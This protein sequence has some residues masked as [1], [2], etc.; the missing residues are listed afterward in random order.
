MTTATTRD[1][2]GIV[3]EDSAKWDPTERRA[4][5]LAHDLSHTSQ[6]G[7]RV[8]STAPFPAYFPQAS[9]QFPQ[10]SVQ[11]RLSVERV[12][13]CA[14]N[15][16]RRISIGFLDWGGQEFGVK[17]AEELGG[18]VLHLQVVRRITVVG[19]AVLEVGKSSLS[20][21]TR[22]CHCSILV[23]SSTSPAWSRCSLCV[24]RAV[25]TGRK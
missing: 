21:V 4:H 5:G 22:G 8:P 24:A 11:R 17:G 14:V 3:R 25:A 12:C 15:N 13:R 20:L 6:G 23:T 1:A 2:R 16:L 9:K 10:L 18:L 19:Q 7:T